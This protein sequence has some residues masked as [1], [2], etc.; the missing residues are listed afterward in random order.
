MA[1]EAKF[2]DVTDAAEMAKVVAVAAHRA[3]PFIYRLI[4]PIETC[5]N[6][7]WPS[8]LYDV[9]AMNFQHAAGVD[10]AC[11][12]C[13]SDWLRRRDVD[14]TPET[15]MAAHGATESEIAAWQQK[16]ADALP[17]HVILEDSQ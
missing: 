3:N 2:I 7:V 12:G 13:V 9:R 8:Q 17:P 10:Y 6:A 15:L 11:D 14:L 5:H 1:F 4:C 16:C